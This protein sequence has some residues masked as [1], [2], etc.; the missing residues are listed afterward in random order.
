MVT[1]NNN[2]VIADSEPDSL[3]SHY[4]ARESL[5]LLMRIAL[6]GMRK[7]FQAVLEKHNIPWSVW[8][9]LRVLWDFDGLTQ[10]ELIK[11]VG[12]MQ[13]N[14][15]SALRTMEKLGY[16]TLEREQQDRRRV[17][18]RLTPYAHNLEA[19]VLPEV[20]ATVEEGPLRNFSRDERE[21]LKSLLVKFC[22]NV[23]DFAD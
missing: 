17:R 4:P 2:T 13:P 1:K 15:V 19:I 11:K 10:S 8:Y 22:S 3:R 14:A 18:V 16:V 5:G 12:V 9:Y 6:F 7:S 23:S 21:Q 20:L